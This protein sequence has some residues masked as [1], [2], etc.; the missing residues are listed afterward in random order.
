VTITWRIRALRDMQEIQAFVAATSSAARGYETL[1]TLHEQINDLSRNPKRGR[2]DPRR[3]G[4]RY[5]I[6][7]AYGHT[8]R[9]RYRLRSDH[10]YVIRV[11]DTRRRDG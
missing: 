1:V 4:T 8:Y 2:I 5:F 10:I 9:V 11:R 3:P 7:P 6:A